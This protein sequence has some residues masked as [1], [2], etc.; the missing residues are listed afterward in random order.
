MWFVSLI[1]TASDPQTFSIPHQKQL[2][3][4]FCFWWKTPSNFGQSKRLRQWNIFRRYPFFIRWNS[5]ICKACGWERHSLGIPTFRYLPF[6]SVSSKW[7]R[8]RSE[9]DWFW[10]IPDMQKFVRSRFFMSTILNHSASVRIPW[11]LNGLEACV[12]AMLTAR[13]RHTCRIYDRME[14]SVLRVEFYTAVVSHC[15]W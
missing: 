5:E 6:F 7:K 15:S 10:G 4:M 14:T 3:K 13:C 11:T 1:L 12:A 8:R 2:S 9:G